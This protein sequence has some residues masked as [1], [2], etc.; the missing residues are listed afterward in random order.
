MPRIVTRTVAACS[1]GI[2]VACG[3]ERAGTTDSVAATASALPT[4]TEGF[5]TPESVRYDPILDVYFVSNI[6]GIP[7][8][9]DNNG[10]I[11][12]VD[13]ANPGTPTV[14]VQGGQGG[15][16]LHAPKG[17]A[18]SG[19]TLWVSDID[20][21]RAFD[22]NTGATLATIAVPNSTFLNDVVVG[23]DGTIYVTD[24]GIRF[25][26]SGEVTHP[27]KDR[28]FAIKDGTVSVAF[29]SD[30]LLARPNGIAW[31]A[32]N[33]RFVIGSFGGPAIIAWKQGETTVTTIGTGPG[34]YDGIE[35]LADGRIVVSSWADSS[36][37]IVDAGQ[38]TRLAGS[39]DGPADIGIDTR[40]ERIA[41]PRFSAGRVDYVALPPR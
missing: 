25:S 30:S 18:L 14:V 31:D 1:L 5:K 21:L 35:V 32:A 28:I 37:N 13:A 33:A 10:Y 9:K 6:D 20:V 3:G 16:E 36:I 39:L 29:E 4:P 27:G 17:L 24:T 26:E 11:A 22:K 15:A 2:L 34:A 23:P 19:D 7:N 8:V 41:I 12:R 38:L 40:R